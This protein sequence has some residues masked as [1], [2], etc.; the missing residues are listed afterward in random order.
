MS[1]RTN[2]RR[3]RRVEG[4]GITGHVK[5]E[6]EVL[7]ALPI[8]NISLGGMLLRTNEPLPVGNQV[9]LEVARKGMKSFKLVGRVLGVVALPRARAGAKHGLAIRFN[10]MSEELTQ[11]LQELISLLDPGAGPVDA[12]PSKQQLMMQSSPPRPRPPSPDFDFE[13]ARAPLAENEVSEAVVGRAGVAG[14]RFE[15]SLADFDF[16]FSQP[17]ATP[18]PEPASVAVP[19]SAGLTVH[20]LTEEAS[21]DDLRELLDAR[22]REVQQ[23]K[24]EL[25]RK[26]EL[27]EKMRSA[28]TELRG[29]NKP[30]L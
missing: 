8:E 7:L 9:F 18:A 30:V 13:H 16:S 10:P 25:A 21:A 12:A 22:E 23:L 1:S 20:L 29:R 24:D 28:L 17:L 11:R 4:E 26:N 19:A 6:G 2:R 5:H 15:R 27:I 14:A 3:H